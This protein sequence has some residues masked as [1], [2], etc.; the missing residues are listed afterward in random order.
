MKLTIDAGIFDKVTNL[1]VG[2][3]IIENADNS[4]DIGDFVKKEYTAIANNVYKK[5]DGVEL[6][7]YPVIKGWRGIYKG[8]GEKK[9]RSS[10]ESLIRRV[11]NG[12]DIY[13]INPLVD[14]YNLASL[15]FEL[16]CGGEDTCII[17]S[18]LELTF[19][20]GDEKFVPLGETE[21][22]N[23]NK[24]EIIYKFGDI[25][26]CRNFNY[27]ESDVTKLTENTKNAIIVF[28]DISGDESR[29]E[30]ALDWLSE[31]ATKLLNANIVKTAI[32]SDTSRSVEW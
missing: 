13:A 24:G 1:R 30:P 14:I 15:K 28:E 12:K 23:P 4:V 5:F 6:A 32:L 25:V 31:K 11:T 16:P 8:F 27:R 2:A 26:V 20:N 9:A 22:E 19:A 7:E 3:I 10:I 17:D 21:I 29:L 18:D